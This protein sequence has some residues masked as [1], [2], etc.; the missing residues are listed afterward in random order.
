MPHSR[1]L[2]AVPATGRVAVRLDTAQ[3]DLFIHAKGTPANLGHLLHRAP[4]RN[5]K[6]TVRL[7]RAELNAL[8]GAAADVTAPDK[9]TERALDTLLRY[10]EGLEDRFEEEQTEEEA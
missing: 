4:V 2:P 8:I 9:K 3:R 1:R 6:L 10:L 5:G 7:S